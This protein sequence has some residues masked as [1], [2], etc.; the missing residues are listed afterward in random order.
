MPFVLFVAALVVASDAG[1]RLGRKAR[2]KAAGAAKSELGAVEGG[3]LA[4]LG[5]LLGFTMSMAVA[6]FEARKQL[7]LEEANAIGTSYLR[8]RLLPAP[9]STEIARLLREYV[10]LRLQ[11]A[12]IRD[13]PDRLHEVREQTARLQDEFWN[14]AVSYAGKAPNPY[15]PG[16]LIQSLNQVID[17]ESA[18]WMAFQNRVPSTVIYVNGDCRRLR[19]HHCRVRFRLRR[20]AAPVP[21][22]VAGACHCGGA[23]RHRRSRPLPEG[24]YPGKSAAYDR[25]ATSV[26]DI[27]TTVRDPPGGRFSRAVTACGCSRPAQRCVAQV[28][29]RVAARTR[30]PPVPCA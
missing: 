12:G 7:V 8:T 20:P 2:A 4:L 22:F 28:R 23:R 27:P 14:R 6:R 5:L 21:H 11:Y 25:S 29:G 17:L 9:Q 16:L 19:S 10:D 3:I 24:F 26:A 18:R 1:F 15:L 13:D 30:R